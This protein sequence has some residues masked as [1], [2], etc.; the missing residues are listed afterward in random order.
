VGCRVVVHCRYSSPAIR[1]EE[2]WG[3]WVLFV[4]WFDGVDSS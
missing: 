3:D 4:E 2:R 1:L